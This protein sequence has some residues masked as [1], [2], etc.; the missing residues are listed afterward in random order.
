MTAARNDLRR[1]LDDIPAVLVDESLSDLI[2]DARNATS[3]LED[4]VD[5]AAIVVVSGPS[6]SGKSTLVNA[7]VGSDVASVSAVRPTTTEVVAIGGSGVD[8]VEEADTVVSVDTLPDGLVVVDTPSWDRAPE[9]VG[10]LM[11][12]A[13]LSIVVVT[14]ARYGDQSVDDAISAAKRADGMELVANR[15][16]PDEI[17]R[18]QISDAIHERLDIEPVASFVEGGVVAFEVSPLDKITDLPDNAAKRRIL[19]KA[20]AGSA[21]RVA[22]AITAVAPGLGAVVRAIG[23][24]EVQAVEPADLTTAAATTWDETCEA[25]SVKAVEMVESVD[26]AIVESA[27]WS[28]AERLRTTLDDPNTDDLRVLLDS[29]KEEV[30]SDAL[31]VATPWFRKKSAEELLRQSAWRLVFDA[32][33][34][35][36]V[37]RLLRKHDPEAIVARNRASLDAL[38]DNAHASRVAQWNDAASTA[39]DYRPGQLI[40]A[41]EALQREAGDG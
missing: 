3:A 7:L 13:V 36:R 16:P 24:T 40:A 20:A 9:V 25:L 10:S 35:P 2:L 26:E 15:L 32:D 31:A 17:A 1:A 37:N 41:A 4:M 22:D 29:W 38:F 19:V 39:G 8:S 28:F 33:V 11:S 12:R 34:P 30:T 18:E 27:G 5:E 14:P 21:R 6:G 23:G